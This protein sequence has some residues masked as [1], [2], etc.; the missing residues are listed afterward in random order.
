MKHL[1]YSA[2]CLLPVLVW[3]TGCTGYI[4]P[5]ETRLELVTHDEHGRNDHF[6][7]F[8]QA[9][10]ARN[11][12]GHL[13]LLFISE[14]PST[15]DPTQTIQQV[16]YIK[17]FW[18]PS[19]GRTYAHKTQVNA[20]IIYAMLTPPTGVRFDGGVFV[21][22]KKDGSDMAGWIES[23]NIR[24]RYRMGGAVEPFGPASLEGT[25]RAEED[26]GRIVEMRN[27]LDTLFKAS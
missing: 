1:C 27:R 15:L 5:T 4:K 14:E 19:P 26:P 3:A 13:E 7:H 6:A 24:P 11:A 10:Y 9:Y 18:S 17:E 22:Y 8:P 25:F 21:T 16:V 2:L 20:N 23:G 12:A